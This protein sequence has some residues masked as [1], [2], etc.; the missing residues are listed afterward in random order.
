LEIGAA[1]QR[2]VF[3]YGVGETGLGRNHV[4]A[5]RNG[6]A[7]EIA[8]CWFRLFALTRLRI[9]DLDALFQ[10]AFIN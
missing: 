5:P 7:G 9:G 2:D 4:V 1:N 6:Q 8:R 3:G 10:S